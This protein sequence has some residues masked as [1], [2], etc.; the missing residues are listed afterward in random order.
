MPEKLLNACRQV[1]GDGLETT[2]YGWDHAESRVWKVVGRN[3]TTYL[4]QY[5]QPRKYRQEYEAYTR[6]LPLLKSMRTPELLASFEGSRTLLFSEAPGELVEEKERHGEEVRDLYRQAGAFLRE[7]HTLPF[8][9]ED[10]LPLN[11]AIAKRTEAWT[12]GRAEGVVGAADVA[13]VR[14]RVAET[15]PVLQAFK[16]VPC[17]RDYTARNWLADEGK[18]YI[19][20]FEHSRPDLWFLDIERL[21]SDVWHTRPDLGEAFWEGYGRTLSDEEAWVLERLAA[22]NALGT[23]IWA[24]EH[25]DAPFEAQGWE[26]LERLKANQT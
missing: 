10:E 19:I 5:R 16:R 11:E 23:I 20:D 21:W 18:L 17:H 13:W 4:K 15:L 12:T 26:R 14:A 3:R 1:L 9:D 25:N 22:F 2:F 7:L 6:W 8:V 24:R